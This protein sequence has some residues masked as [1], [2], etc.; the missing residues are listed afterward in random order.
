MVADE[1]PTAST[2]CAVK[3]TDA[4]PT[5]EVVLPESLSVPLPPPPDDEDFDPDDEDMSSSTTVN[6][7]TGMAL[8]QRELGAQVIAEYD[9]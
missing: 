8:V 5:S 1:A 4:G 7:L 6:D 9:D 2:A 3:V